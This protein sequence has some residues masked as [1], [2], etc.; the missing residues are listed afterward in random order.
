MKR[1][2]LS[3]LVVFVLQ[4]IS[5]AWAHGAENFNS[6]PKRHQKRE[7]RKAEDGFA[8]NGVIAHR[9]AWKAKKLPKNSIASL[10]QAMKLGVAG[11]EFDIH[12]TADGVLVIHHDNTFNGLTIEKTNYADLLKFKLPNGEPIPTLEHY[13]QTGMTQHRTRLI[14]EL[15]PSVIS[16]ERS[17]ELADKVVAMVQRLHAQ[18][19]MVYISFSYDILQRIHELDPKARLMPLQNKVGIPQMKAD[20]M[21]GIDFYFG[22]FKKN[23]ELVEVAHSNGLKVNAWTVDKPGVMDELLH[24]GGDFITTDEPEMLLKKVSRRRKAA[25]K[26]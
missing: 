12:E 25:G 17:L 23:P 7:Q 26:R 4:G 6:P 13:I 8:A 1:F 20:G 9:G 16:K 5:D 19:W 2:I 3:L 22:A 21:W 14:A 15:K 11:S 10:K 24:Q 18:D